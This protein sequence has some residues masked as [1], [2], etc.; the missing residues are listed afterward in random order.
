MNGPPSSPSPSPP[1]PYREGKAL[2]EIIPPDRRRA[3]ATALVL[4][5]MVAGVVLWVLGGWAIAA[6][7]SRETKVPAPT[8]GYYAGR[9]GPSLL[10]GPD[11]QVAMPPL[12]RSVVHVWLQGCGD[13]MPAFEAMRALQSTGGLQ[14]DA[15]VVNVAYGEADLT[16]AQ[17]YGVATN[18]VFDPGGTSVVRPLGIGTF[19]T[20]VVEPNGSI[21]HR[22]RPDQPGYLARVRSAVEFGNPNVVP[23]PDPRD[24][25]GSR[26]DT[27]EATDTTLDAAS[28]QRVVAAHR[29]GIKRTCWERSDDDRRSAS[30]DVRLTIDTDGRVTTARATGDD[31]VVA[32]CIEAQTRTWL[33]PSPSSQTT[34]NIPFKFIRE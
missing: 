4:V 21:I 9:I 23:A 24:P 16:W 8:P 25:L 1:A 3:K 30:V 26:T 32:K 14:V 10:R 29:A 6:I 7:Q 2:A 17:R 11:A 15:P 19:M 12:R 34:V 27:P 22:D 33:F 18:L 13:C 20:L 31:P 5:S 28:V